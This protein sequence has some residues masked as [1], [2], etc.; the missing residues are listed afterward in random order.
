VALASNCPVLRRLQVL[1]AIGYCTYTIEDF[2]PTAEQFQ[3]DRWLIPGK[4]AIATSRAKGSMPFGGGP[5]VCAGEA[6]AWA[7]MKVPAPAPPVLTSLACGSSADKADLTSVKPFLL[8]LTC[9]TH[10]F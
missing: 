4:S 1:L 8:S 2:L 6:L 3:P 7:E 5:R 10:N 9:S